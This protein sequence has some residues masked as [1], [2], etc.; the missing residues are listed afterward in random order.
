MAQPRKPGGIREWLGA[1]L[2]RR[3]LVLALAIFYLVFFL[4]V[5]SI[6]GPG[7]TW[8]EPCYLT[9]GHDFCLPWFARIGTDA[10]SEKAISD[11]WAPVNWHPPLGQLLIGI[12]QRLFADWLGRLVAGRLATA[13][14][15]AALAAG[16]YLFMA[17]RYD[18]KVGLLSTVCLVGMP[19]VFGHA[20]FAAFDLQVAAAWFA[21]TASFVLGITSTRWRL[22][23]G[24]G[25]GAGLLLKTSLVPLPLLLLAWALLYHGRRAKWPCL[26]L[27]LAV[28]VFFLW[29]WLWF[30]TLVH[31]KDYLGIVHNR[32]LILVY[33]FGKSMAHSQVPFHYPLVMTFSTTPLLIVLAALVGTVH[34]LKRPKADPVGIL[35][36]ATVVFVL[37][38]ASAPGMPRYDG[39]R[40]F[41]QIFPF[42]AA[43][44]GIGLAVAWEYARERF[45][46]RRRSGQALAAAFGVYHLGWLVVLHP[47]YLSDYGGLVGATPGASRLGLE[48]TYWCETLD[49]KTREYVNRHAPE[50]ARIAV[51]P[52]AHMMFLF[53]QDH[54]SF[55]EDLS[56]VD[57]TRDQSWDI[58][59]LTCRRGMFD[60]ELWRYHRGATPLFERNLLGVPLCQVFKKTGFEQ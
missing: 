16:L 24:L 26:A 18:E 58:L 35:W 13:S 22:A 27:G 6:S 50:G 11:H 46:L 31:L 32:P 36:V 5:L 57:R 41:L 23:A 42:I 39:V 44:A 34:L 55:R 48:T 15:F 37:V 60:E 47:F 59:V 3:R 45:A 33:Y 38:I 12:G 20:H 7:V 53:F 19:R 21:V 14:V 40:L 1:S 4:L 10:L 2:S 56:L 25:L 29:P 17:W 8:D 30:D 28:P 49:A 52:Y 54:A 9:G 43:L 51:H